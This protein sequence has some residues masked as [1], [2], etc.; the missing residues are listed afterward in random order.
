ME[1]GLFPGQLSAPDLAVDESSGLVFLADTQRGLLFEVDTAT[2]EVRAAAGVGV[3]QVELDVE[4]LILDY[5]GDPFEFVMHNP[6]STVVLGPRQ[7]LKWARRVD[8]PELQVLI[9]LQRGRVV[10]Y[11]RNATAHRIETVAGLPRGDLDQ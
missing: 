4:M 3:S 10:L 6:V 1:M 5:G 9:T 8:N 2:A 11:S 7:S